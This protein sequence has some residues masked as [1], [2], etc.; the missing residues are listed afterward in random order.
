MLHKQKKQITLLEDPQLAKQS[1]G[2]S[3][4]LPFLDFTKDKADEH[5]AIVNTE[6]KIQ[7]RCSLWYKEK[8]LL[9]DK[10][11]GFIGHYDAINEEAAL[12]LLNHA[13]AQLEQYN[14]AVAI[15]PMD[16][17]TWRRY[18]FI[19][20]RG[21]DPV[22]FLEPSNPDY[23][24]KHF[25]FAGF[26]PLAQY[27]SALNINLTLRD[28]KADAIENRFKTAGISLRP[29]SKQ[30][31][32]ADLNA[33]FQLSLQSFQSNFLYSPIAEDEFMEKYQTLLPVIKANFLLIAEDKGIP[34]G[35][36]LALPNY[37]EGNKPETIILKTVARHPANK[38]AGLGRFLVDKVQKEAFEN[39][40][41][42]VIH[43]L[44]ID[45]NVSGKISLRYASPIRKYTLY[46]RQLNS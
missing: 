21:H 18:R 17:N 32:N 38:Y 16:G 20:E 11:A 31:S 1:Y 42:R 23:Y 14:C 10:V 33:I 26:Q 27:F 3:D 12:V 44:M 46:S 40:Y 37:N 39:D 6:N 22:F 28:P 30:N 45:R 24:P 13:F 4:A 25:L 41:S 8:I 5:W 36:V 35:F 29:F 43:A 2:F 15:G 34:V 7:A 9:A 19:S